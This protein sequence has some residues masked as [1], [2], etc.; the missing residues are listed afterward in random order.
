M[1]YNLLVYK[2]ITNK[3]CV[4]PIKYSISVYR[5]VTN[6]PPIDVL[7]QHKKSCI[8]CKRNELYRLP[9]PRFHNE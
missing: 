4:E 9:T 1:E 3:K 7:K 6:K 5:N 2:Q 8:S